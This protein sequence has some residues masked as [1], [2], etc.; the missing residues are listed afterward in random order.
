MSMIFF[1]FGEYQNTIRKHH[2]KYIQMLLEN[3]ANQIYKISK[4]INQTEWHDYPLK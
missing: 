3:S 4:R 2:N 1:A